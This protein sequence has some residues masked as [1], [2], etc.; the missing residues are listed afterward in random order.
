MNDQHQEQP[1]SK[2][3]VKPWF[4]QGWTWLIVALIGISVI[5]FG[6]MG[7]T[8][9]V[10]EVNQSIQENTVAIK[11]QTSILTDINQGIQQWMV[12]LKDTVTRILDSI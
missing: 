6:F 2:P 4:N 9:Q 3:P 12:E 1:K 5:Y 11:E 10:T 7:L 8:E